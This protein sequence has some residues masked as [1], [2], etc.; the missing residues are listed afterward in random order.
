MTALMSIMGVFVLILVLARYK[1][2]L[3]LAVL[4]GALQAA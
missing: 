3:A 1:V 4:V 2:P